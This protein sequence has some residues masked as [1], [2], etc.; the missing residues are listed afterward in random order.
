LC[1]SWSG[2]A[3]YIVGDYGSPD[4]YGIPTTTKAAPERHL[5]SKARKE[6]ENLAERGAAMLEDLEKENR[7]KTQVLLCQ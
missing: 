4:A 5:Y 6:Y 3:L 7:L 1:G 2:D